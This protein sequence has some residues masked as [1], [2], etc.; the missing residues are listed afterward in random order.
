MHNKEEALNKR[1]M[2]MHVD[3]MEDDEME[4]EGSNEGN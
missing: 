3:N 1:E 4:V 2:E